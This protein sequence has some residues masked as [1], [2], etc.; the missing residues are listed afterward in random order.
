MK[1]II[2]YYL[3]NF[4][5]MTMMIEWRVN[6]SRCRKCVARLLLLD[7]VA[8]WS[9][10]DGETLCLDNVSRAPS[11]ATSLNVLWSCAGLLELSVHR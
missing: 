3:L 4:N 11:T 2:I 9:A 7:N 6:S 8:H 10:V 1:R 5:G